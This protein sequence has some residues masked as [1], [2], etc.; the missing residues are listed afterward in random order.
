M[1]VLLAGDLCGRALTRVAL[2]P[3]AAFFRLASR[4]FTYVWTQCCSGSPQNFWPF[5][6]VKLQEG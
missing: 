3:V 5:R 4:F 2:S 1:A 6:V